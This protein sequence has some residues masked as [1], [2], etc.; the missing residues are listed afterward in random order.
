MEQAGAMRHQNL[1]SAAH[2]QDY[3]VKD[4]AAFGLRSITETK[5]QV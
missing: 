3:I 5:C 2:A 1:T 4:I